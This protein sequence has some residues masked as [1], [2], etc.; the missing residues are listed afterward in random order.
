MASVGTPSLKG[1]ANWILPPSQLHRGHPSALFLTPGILDLIAL[2][3]GIRSALFLILW[4][5]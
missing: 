3:V 1:L 4:A 5:R 2:F